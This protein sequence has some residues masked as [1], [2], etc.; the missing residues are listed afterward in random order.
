MFYAVI[1]TLGLTVLAG[2]SVAGARK[3]APEEGIYSAFYEVPYD[4]VLRASLRAITKLGL[5]VRDQ[6]LER[7]CV[8]GVR[9]A[10]PGEGSRDIEF[11]LEKAGPEKTWVRV[12]ED[13]SVSWGNSGWSER[14]FELLNQE[15]KLETKPSK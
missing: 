10:Q 11:C 9:D 7:G 5:E 3:N 4:N 12:R 2:C 13:D 14:F 8:R 6:D 1:L 15:L